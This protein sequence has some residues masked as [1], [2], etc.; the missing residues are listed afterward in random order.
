MFKTIFYTY[1]FDLLKSSF[2]NNRVLSQVVMHIV[3]PKR[4]K[5]E[6]CVKRVKCVKPYSKT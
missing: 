1:K 2:K 6:N 3:E 4:K 5:I